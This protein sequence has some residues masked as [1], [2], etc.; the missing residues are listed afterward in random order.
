MLS[1][2]NPA[3]L[4]LLLAVP[5][6]I[7]FHSMSL[8]RSRKRAMLFANFEALKRAD[9][10]YKYP[11]YIIWLTFR[12]M[13]IVMFAFAMAGTH[14]NYETSVNYADYVLALDASSSMSTTDIL[15]SRFEAAKDAEILFLDT[16]SD[17]G[18]K[19]RVSL[20]TFAGTTLIHSPPTYDMF[21][22]K[23]IVKNLNLSYV[24]GTAIGEAIVNSVNI[25]YASDRAKVIYLITDGASN[26][27]VDVDYAINYAKKNGVV[28][29]TIGVGTNSET[30]FEDRLS[31]SLDQET[32]VNIANETTGSY[33]FVSNT[34][35]LK[36][37][38]L[39]EQI[40]T[41]GIYD[42]DLTRYLLFAILIM[43]LTEWILVN[44]RIKAIP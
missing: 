2:E 25:L 23:G 6:V 20:V 40:R 21:Y 10:R 33:H 27:G 1:F 24:P 17:S 15:P 19:S 7:F 32:L 34:E 22:T 44:T 18:V 37:V 35:E 13:I 5:I 38:F 36:A 4:V 43:F 42:L 31:T 12:I 41:Y 8:H 39:N 3:F 26:V 11:K 14:I 28:I 29:N 16:I 30:V 9:Q